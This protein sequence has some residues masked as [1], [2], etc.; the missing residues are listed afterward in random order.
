MHRKLPHVFIGAV[1]RTPLGSFEGALK[2]LTA[3]E[4]GSLAIKGLLA[5]SSITGDK[6][7][8]L[9][10]GNVLQAGLGQAPARQAA[11]NAGLP[12]STPSTTI[13]KVC[14]SGMKATQ[15][16]HD[17]IVAGHNNIVICGGQESISNVPFTI[18]RYAPR[19]GGDVMRDL[20]NNDGH[21]TKYK[22]QAKLQGWA[23]IKSILLLKNNQ[24]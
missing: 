18:S 17:S 12:N 16:G 2:G 20:V 24:L 21:V 13:N 14:A 19:Y 4:L 1:N 15:I 7:D 10:F 22:F 8:E 6:I 3:P 23:Y 11:L 9:F 5:K